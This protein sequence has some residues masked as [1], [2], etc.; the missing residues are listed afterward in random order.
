MKDVHGGANRSEEIKNYFHQLLKSSGEEGDIG[1]TRFKTVFDELMPIQKEKLREIT[2]S[3]FDMLMDEGSMISIGITYRDPIID[4][5]DSVKS[6][7]IDYQLWNEYALEYD[8]LNQLLNRMSKDIADKFGG[9][10]MKATIGGIIGEINHVTDY[11]DKVISH[12]V[13]AENAGLGWRGKNQ[14]MIH[15]KFSCAIRFASVI[16]PYALDWNEKSEAKCGSCTACEEVCSFI[17]NREILPDYRENCRR[18][19]LF[20]QSKG[21][22]KDICGKCIKACYQKSV[23][24]DVFSLRS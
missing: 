5:I 4:C 21:I 10:A 11:Y 15:E 14:L 9:I 2:A 7:E 16:V 13:V 19:I 22:E 1:F 23:F 20:L 18:Y 24:S 17:R 3:Q 6:G 8:R 12:R